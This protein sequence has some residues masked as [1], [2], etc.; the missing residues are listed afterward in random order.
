MEAEGKPF[1]GNGLGEE[2]IRV[3]RYLW[4]S[5]FPVKERWLGS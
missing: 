3:K 2:E 5:L 4:F 1:E